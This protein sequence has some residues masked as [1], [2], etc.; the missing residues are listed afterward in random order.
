MKFLSFLVVS[1]FSLQVFAIDAEFLGYL[2]GGTG[3]NFQGGKQECFY[4]QGI[5][6]NF[7]RLGNECSFYSEIAVIFHHKKPT[8]ED[9]VFFRT[10]VRMMFNALGTSQWEPA[11]TR[12]INQIE[13]F[14]TAGGLSELPG[15]LWV[16]KRFYRDVDLHIFD[17]YYYADM[18]GVGAGW[19]NIQAGPGLFSIAHL[20]QTNE[21]V[22]TDVGRPTLQAIDL[23]WAQVPLSHDHKLNFWGVF[24]WA[25]AGDDGTN[26]YVASNGYSVASRMESFIGEGVNNFS[27]MYGKGTMKDFNIY[28]SSAV[29]ATD[30]SQ[31]KAWSVRA[32]ENW[33]KE[34]TDRWAFMLG[35]AGEY[36]DT[37]ADTD[38]RRY[39]YEVGLRPLYYVTDRFQWV[40]ELG[41]SRILN[42][43]EKTGGD[44]VGERDLSRIT[45]APQI[46][47]SKS[48]WG[49]PV[50]RAFVTHTIWNTANK[51]Y[52]GVSAP[53]FKEE[54][55]GTSFGYQF[56]AWF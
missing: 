7:L 31:N 39:F 38:S 50:L 51:S 16:G 18:S 23:R 37:G 34:V 3:L 49:R 27:L 14:V 36:G 48:I 20:I 40:L 10:Q 24:S 4:N 2:R 28:A 45:L 26:K 15:E 17:W 5:P 43:S 6:G 42:E 19:Q 33:N 32:V 21:N 22:Q 53:S 12:D 35:L 29:P 25:P 56:E 47:F 11:S 41:Y 30:D 13:A 52:V 9:S 44:P 55:A 54:T 1:F 46:S 8:V